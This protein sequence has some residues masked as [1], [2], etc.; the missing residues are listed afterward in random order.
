MVT[1]TLV[2]AEDGQHPASA[3]WEFRCSHLEAAV[4]RGRANALVD[5]LRPGVVVWAP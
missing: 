1:M 3:V 5:L 2:V 4:N